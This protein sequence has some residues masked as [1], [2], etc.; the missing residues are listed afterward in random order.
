MRRSRLI[1]LL[2]CAALA[3]LVALPAAA[4]ANAFQDLFREY[5]KAG[6]IDGCK[7]SA[8]DLEAAKRQVP[9]DIE[10]YAPDF[11]QALEAAASARTSGA[12]RKGADADTPHRVTYKKLVRS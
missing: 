8:A 5:R 2:S 1:T 10:Q 3:V 7:H 9:N 6:K 4:S 11:P 12:C